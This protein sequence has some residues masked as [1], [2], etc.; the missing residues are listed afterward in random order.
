MTPFAKP[1]HTRY[2]GAIIREGHI[3]LIQHRFHGNGH[4][5]WL[6]PGGGLEPGESEVEC[7]RREMRE[8]T[9]LEV[10]VERLLL[11]ELAHRNDRT[12]AVYKT[13]LCRPIGG[14]TRPGYEPEPDAA[15]AYAIAAVGWF[16]LRDAAA[17]GEA[18]R[19]DSHTHGLLTKLQMALGYE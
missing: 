19:A 3:L 10:A 9:G 18:I 4:S 12:Y 14:E 13:F 5:Y 8:E 7:V 6:I 1:R 11:E 16:D 2:Q 15:S 17:W